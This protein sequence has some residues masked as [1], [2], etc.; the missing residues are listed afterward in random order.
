MEVRTAPKKVSR[1][2]MSVLERSRMLE[3]KAVGAGGE[4]GGNRVRRSS[5]RTGL[6][7]GPGGGRVRRGGSHA[8][9][10]RGPIS[11]IPRDIAISPSFRVGTGGYIRHAQAGSAASPRR[12]AACRA[13]SASSPSS[14]K[15]S[16]PAYLERATS[17]SSY[18][19]AASEA[20]SLT[21]PSSCTDGTS[22]SSPAARTAAKGPD[23]GGVD[24]VQ[25]RLARAN[26]SAAAATETGWPARAP[27][28]AAVSPG[29]GPSLIELVAAAPVCTLGVRADAGHREV[30]IR[31]GSLAVSDY[32]EEDDYSDDDEETPSVSL[33]DMTSDEDEDDEDDV[34]SWVDDFIESMSSSTM[35]GNDGEDEWIDDEAVDC[36]GKRDLESCTPPQNSPA[37]VRVLPSSKDTPRK[38]KKTGRDAGGR[39]GTFASDADVGD[40]SSSLST[41]IRSPLR[42]PLTSPPLLAAAPSLRLD[43]SSIS[44]SAKTERRIFHDNGK[45][46]DDDRSWVDEFVKSIG[47]STSG[48]VDSSSISHSATTE[49]RTFHDNGKVLDDDRSWVDE[50]V[51]S[52][53]SSSEVDNCQ[54]CEGAENGPAPRAADPAR[55]LVSPSRKDTRRKGVLWKNDRKVSGSRCVTFAPGTEAGVPTSSLPKAMRSA[56]PPA[57][58]SRPA[59]NDFVG[60]C[61][62]ST[63]NDR[64]VFHAHDVHRFD[65]WSTDFK[66]DTFVAFDDDFFGRHKF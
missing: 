28:A 14:L 50:F 36:I 6:A 21:D 63:S 19:G 10:G 37:R 49:R 16:L 20:T 35:R 55:H 60:R 45:D 24:E 52:M 9:S 38:K 61:E 59:K 4:G 58:K 31:R 64:K 26:I 2:K 8:D 51:K 44:H 11:G 1:A 27:A 5:T 23:R 22:P 13:S 65:D 41:A 47:S 15:G 25:H 66:E 30:V 57:P 43:S 33:D 39:F 54:G 53:G 46:L 32:G 56:L 42:S 48:Q 18:D 12:R 34:K 7:R 62:A 17:A 3:G 29:F 40:P